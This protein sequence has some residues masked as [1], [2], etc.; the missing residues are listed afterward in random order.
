MT[1][2]WQGVVAVA[3]LMMACGMR[4]V[5]DDEL[6]EYHGGPSMMFC[7]QR[8]SLDRASVSCSGNRVRMG[9]VAKFEGLKSLSLVDD[10]IE[11]DRDVVLAS[12]EDLILANVGS[13]LRRLLGAFPG[14]RDLFLGGG[15]VDFEMLRGRRELRS[16]SVT[17]GRFPRS[18]E[19]ANF[20]RLN[21][22]QLGGRGCDVPGCA[23][24][25]L[26]VLHMRRP[27]IQTRLDGHL[28]RW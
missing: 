21:Y 14:A 9:D 15:D 22:V 12:V 8:W 26:A 27:D 28:I 2:G 25:A 16:L 13:D 20:P 19:L 11:W 23:I 24:V 10:Q 3:A 6:S 1:A 7:G 5:P 4:D 18:A 17:D